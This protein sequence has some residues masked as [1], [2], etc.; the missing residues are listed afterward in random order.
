[1]SI[2]E[3]LR[4]DHDRLRAEMAALGSGLPDA[5]RVAAFVRDLTAHAH[6]ED[7]L[8]FRE[9][10]K[11]LPADHGPL[12]VMREEHEEIES[13]LARIVAL[14]PAAAEDRRDEM[15]RLSVVAREHFLKEEEVLFAFAERLI[16]AERLDDLGK[17]FRQQVVAASS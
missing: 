14:D 4:S 13:R 6:G 2:L 9:L 3:E 15:R 10:E 7:E 8:L 17:L 1:M 5:D 11:G 12:A 16:D